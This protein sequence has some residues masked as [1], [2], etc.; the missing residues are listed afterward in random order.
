MRF[1]FLTLQLLSMRFCPFNLKI[2]LFDSDTKTYGKDGE[3][4]QFGNPDLQKYGLTKS[5]K[6][7]L[8]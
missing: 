5:R 4:L 1:I 6:F 2:S 8:K 3:T 7:N